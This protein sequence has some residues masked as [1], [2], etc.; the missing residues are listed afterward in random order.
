MKKIGPLMIAAT[1]L[2][3]ILGFTENAI[4]EIIA[5]LPGHLLNLFG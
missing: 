1:T 3:L 4:A 2:G 5:A